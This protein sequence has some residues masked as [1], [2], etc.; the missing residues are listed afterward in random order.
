VTAQSKRAF[1]PA[2][3]IMAQGRYDCALAQAVAGVASENDDDI[4]S[5]ML[6]AYNAGPAAV[7]AADGVPDI[8]HTETYVSS[9]LAALSILHGGS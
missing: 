3:A 5:L 1:V 6:A 2:D 4:T 8:P 7:I 9:V